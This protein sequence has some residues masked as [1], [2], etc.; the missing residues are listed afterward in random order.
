MKTLLAAVTAAI[1][2]TGV[3]HAQDGSDALGKCLVDS[4]TGKDRA[5]FT[6][7]MFMALAANPAVKDLTNIPADRRDQTD[8]EMAGVMNRLVLVDCRKEAARALKLG[9]PGAVSKSFEGFGRIAVTD[10]MGDRDVDAA[11]GRFS[12]YID[13]NGWAKFTSGAGADGKP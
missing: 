12:R 8:R 9:G 10:L 3:A 2:M 5:I 13:Q 6:Q 11:L 1:A 7:W 4:S